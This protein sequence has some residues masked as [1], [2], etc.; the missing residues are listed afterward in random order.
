MSMPFFPHFD[1]LGLGRGSSFQAKR[2][3]QLWPQS[4]PDSEMQAHLNDKL[5]AQSYRDH[6]IQ[7]HLRAI[8]LITLESLRDL[9]ID[10]GISDKDLYRDIEEEIARRQLLDAIDARSRSSVRPEAS[11]NH[12]MTRITPAP[13][14][15]A[16]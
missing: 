11:L 8:D 13:Q 1:E 5:K 6:E 2:V 3:M 12:S 9:F 15:P 7:A 4:H 10:L 16:I 14:K